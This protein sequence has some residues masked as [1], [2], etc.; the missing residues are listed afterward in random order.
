MQQPISSDC[1]K[2]YQFSAIQI[3]IIAAI[4]DYQGKICERIS[5]HQND[6]KFK[7]NLYRH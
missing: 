4:L 2:N 1:I 3:L 5:L 6:L 7:N